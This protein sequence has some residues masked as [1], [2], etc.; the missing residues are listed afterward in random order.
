MPQRR[1]R[2]DD[3]YVEERFKNTDNRIDDHIELANERYKEI[4]EMIEKGLE[5]KVSN[6]KFK[7]FQQ[8]GY[9][10]MGALGTLLL[11]LIIYVLTK[12]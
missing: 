12:Q 9:W 1:N 8:S 11:S 3:R 6:E 2:Y 7:P 4:K 5:S 10:F